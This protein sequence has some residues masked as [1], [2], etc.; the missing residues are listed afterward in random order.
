MDEGD[1]LPELAAIALGV[2]ISVVIAVN[3]LSEV[4]WPDLFPERHVE[5][6]PSAERPAVHRPVRDDQVAVPLPPITAQFVAAGIERD[7]WRDEPGRPVEIAQSA[8]WRRETRSTADGVNNAYSDRQTGASITWFLATDGSREALSAEVAR[9]PSSYSPVT[10]ANAGRTE[11]GAR[12][13][14][15]GLD[16]RLDKRS[17]S[18]PAALRILH[19]R[20]RHHALAA[21]PSS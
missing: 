9:N 14:V 3:V 8:N 2:T 10:Y 5:R 21:F 7:A 6:P 20:R 16:R 1:G 17:R 4:P 11:Q 19:H 15:H 13:T 18:R 12:R